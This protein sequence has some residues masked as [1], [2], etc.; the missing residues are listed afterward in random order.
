V[1]KN[2][3]GSSTVGKC[4]D[5]QIRRWDI[6]SL[7]AAEGDQLVFPLAFKPDD[8]PQVKLET[9]DVRGPTRVT[10]EA[11]LYV[12]RGRIK[13]GPDVLNADDLVWLRAPATIDR[14]DIEQPVIVEITGM[15][16]QPMV[17]RKA[18]TKSYPIAGGKGQATLFLDG[19][20][21]PIAIEKITAEKGVKIPPHTHAGSEELLYIVSGKG[22][23]R[24][25]DK[26]VFTTAGTI[27][28]IPAGVEHSLTVDEPLVAV[29]VYAPG[30]PEQRFK[31][32]AKK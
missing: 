6:S 13:A 3:S 14:V 21:Q 19:T 7:K 18:L 24:I 8:Q 17:V 26:P 4:I 5:D 22:M 10:Q 30:G 1:L 25:G 28:R 9:L 23:T 16:G 11:V 27:L 2:Q 12:V 20:S 32:E 15:T 31:P 29:Q